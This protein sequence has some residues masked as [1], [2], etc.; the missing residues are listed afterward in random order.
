MTQG[1]RFRPLPS[2]Q[3]AQ[4]NNPF[5]N[6][7]AIGKRKAEVSDNPV[8]SLRPPLKGMLTR[9]CPFSLQEEGKENQVDADDADALAGG[10]AA[11]LAVDKSQ[12]H[13]LRDTKRRAVKEEEDG[14]MA[15]VATRVVCEDVLALVAS[16]TG[17]SLNERGHAAAAARE[18]GEAVEEAAAGSAE[19]EVEDNLA[20]EDI[21][22]LSD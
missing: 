11:R 15:R 12:Q 21:Y 10:L 5:T 2:V 16:F 3:S 13:H 19:A 1:F 22:G 4:L 9:I 8:S 18:D 20:E 7:S 6:Q 17:F 14:E